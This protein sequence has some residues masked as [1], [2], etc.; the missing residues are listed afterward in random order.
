MTKLIWGMSGD[1]QFETGIDRGVLY[2]PGK[3]GVVWNGLISIKE[4]PSG[5]QP[6]PYYIDGFKYS[7]F[8][9]AEEYKATLEAFSAPAEFAECDGSLEIAPGL[10]ATQQTRR[11]F[12]FSYRTKIGNDVRGVDFAS[13]IHIV[14]NA[15]AEPT[16]KSYNTLDRSGQPAALSW[17]FSTIPVAVRPGV[18]PTAHLELDSR[19]THPLIM[20][21]VEGYLYGTTGSD[22]RLPNPTE[23]IPLINA[24]LSPE[25]Q[26]AYDTVGVVV[27]DLWP[28]S[29]GSVRPTGVPVGQTIFWFDTSSP[30]YSTVRFVTG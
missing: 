6:K 17:D 20:S 11:P 21:V 25:V 8:A 16:S 18:R 27:D 14:Y 19:A 26:T 13:K 12:S 15:Q 23:L 3:P 22:P 29:I 9:T 5:G 28:I 24:R 1:R 7:N 4:N 2:R 30:A 10:F